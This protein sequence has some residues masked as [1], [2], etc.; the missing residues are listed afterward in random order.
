MVAAGFVRRVVQRPVRAA[1]RREPGGSPTATSTPR[2]EV[3]GRH[4]LARLAEAFN[5]MAADLGGARREVTA[6]SQK[7]EEKVVEKTEEL[8]RAQRQVLHME[9]M[10]SLGK[11]SA[12]VAHEL[13]NPIS[14]ML[15]YARLVRREIAGN[16]IETGSATNSTRNLILVEKECSRCG[17]HRAEPAALRAADGGDHVAGGPERGGRAEP[18]AGSASPGNQRGKAAQRAVR[19]ERPDRGRRR[20]SSSRPWS[21][22][23]S[24]P[25]RR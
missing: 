5:Q 21:P 6:W 24:T 4:E 20:A 2:I 8:G 1:L 9:K 7:L 13:N 3:R 22:C 12:T 23:W 10:A 15:T 25:S 18:D 19:G 16:R 11:L 14:G 17:G